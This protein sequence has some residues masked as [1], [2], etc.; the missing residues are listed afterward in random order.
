[1]LFF[2]IILLF[3]QYSTLKQKKIISHVSILEYLNLPL[4]FHLFPIKTR[5]VKKVL[6]ANTHSVH[7][8]FIFKNKIK[9]LKTNYIL[10]HES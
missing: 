9:Y 7:L 1:M 4:L 8:F 2:S 6:L 3:P 10:I 5:L